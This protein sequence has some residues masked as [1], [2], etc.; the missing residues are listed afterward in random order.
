MSRVSVEE[1][2]MSGWK[3]GRRLETE[4]RKGVEMVELWSSWNYFYL[5]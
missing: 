3:D 1:V 4:V 5:T 2:F